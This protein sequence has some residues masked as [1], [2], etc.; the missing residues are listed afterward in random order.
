MLDDCI[1]V[2]SN[3]DFAYRVRDAAVCVVRQPDI[4]F[5]DT[6]TSQLC[7]ILLCRNACG[8]HPVHNIT[9]MDIVQGVCLY[10]SEVCKEYRD[11]IF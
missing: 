9:S 6:H 8:V 2:Y 5:H 1:R 3:G 10:M 4:A 7:S 11:L